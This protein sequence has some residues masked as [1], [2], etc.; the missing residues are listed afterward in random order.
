[1]I[2][3][4]IESALAALIAVTL[5]KAADVPDLW[6]LLMSGVGFLVIHVVSTLTQRALGIDD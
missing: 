5:G 1:M 3:V 4:L 6:I 2:E